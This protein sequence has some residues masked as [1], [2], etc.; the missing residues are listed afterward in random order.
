MTQSLAL[1][2]FSWPWR[3]GEAIVSP[4]FN[5]THS[6]VSWFAQRAAN[7]DQ[8][9]TSLAPLA[10]QLGCGHV[11]KWQPSILISPSFAAFLQARLPPVDP[12]DAMC[13]ESRLQS[14]S[15]TSPRERPAQPRRICRT[16]YAH[17]ALRHQIGA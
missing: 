8:Q 11:L 2:A 15:R 17:R 16:A 4:I 6:R 12:L 9:T 1:G 10:S 7:E 14:G 13:L 5:D 3:S